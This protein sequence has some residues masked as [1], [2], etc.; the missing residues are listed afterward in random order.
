MRSS[1]SRL[2]KIYINFTCEIAMLPWQLLL[3]CQM[4]SGC[5]NVTDTDFV[6]LKNAAGNV[7]TRKSVVNW[8]RIP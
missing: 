6:P 1:A 7:N 5:E 4:A 2:G 8:V 3:Q